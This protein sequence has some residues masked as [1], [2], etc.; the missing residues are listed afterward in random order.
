MPDE[1]FYHCS[2]K[3]V[4]RSNGRSVVAA[5]AYRSGE[6]LYDERSGQTADYSRRDGVADTF[7][8]ARPDAP[9]WVKNRETLWNAA[10]R[11]ETRR[12]ARLATEVEVALP[13]ELEPAAR[14]QLVIDFATAI[15]EARGVVA[16][17]AI[18]APGRRGDNRNHHA[19]ILFTHRSV[20]REGFIQKAPGA[21]K[22]RGLSKWAAG[23]KAV[24]AIRQGW[25]DF[26]N[27]AYRA[28][29]MVKRVCRRS[30]K[31]RFFPQEPTVHLG[32][33]AT[34]K[35]RRGQATV[36]GDINRAIKARNDTLT[37]TVKAPSRQ[38]IEIAR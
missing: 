15:V 11:S 19:H 23:R 12:N 13:Y 28:A 33:V 16:D 1:G 24:E 20:D 3:A 21:H 26:V 29:R 30:F 2:V 25:E 8:V 9:L 31:D 5:A 14:K 6:V 22:D 38:Q 17:V 32:P 35:E 34:Q 4:G 36:E 18:H 37:P 27:L 7:I 10:E